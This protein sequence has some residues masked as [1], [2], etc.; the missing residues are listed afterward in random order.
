[1]N[2]LKEIKLLDSKPDFIDDNF[3]NVE[4]VKRIFNHCEYEGASETR[5]ICHVSL[6]DCIFEYN[7]LFGTNYE[8]E[9]D[10]PLDFN[11]VYFK[12]EISSVTIDYTD[13][14]KIIN[15]TEDEIN[16]ELSF[17][18]IGKNDFDFITNKFEDILK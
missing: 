1:M 9:M 14:N 8:L 5:A 11:V 4:Y 7:D 3:S 18:E 10:K 2:S 16:Y 15:N 13:I 12:S 6:N 17:S